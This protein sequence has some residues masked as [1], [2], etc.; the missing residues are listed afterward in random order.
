MR[1]ANITSWQSD[2]RMISMQLIRTRDT[3]RIHRK[4]ADEIMPQMLKLS[5]DIARRL[6]DKTSISDITSMEDNPEWEELLEKSGVADSLKELMQLQEE[7]GDIMMATFSNLKSFPFFND[8]ANWFVPFRADH[9]AVSGNGGEDM[10]KI[11]SLL[12]S[13][14]VF[15]DGDKYS[16]AL[17][18]LSMPEEQRK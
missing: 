8:A 7:G 4:L 6:S 18:L 12:E 9:P 11:A 2:V 10:K 5:P 13:M 15:C 17:M 14:N 16:F 3:E 1:Y